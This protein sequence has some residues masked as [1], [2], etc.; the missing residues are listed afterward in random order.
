MG[1]SNVT[2]P[3][4]QRSFSRS[5]IWALLSPCLIWALPSPSQIFTN[6]FWRSTLT[7]QKTLEN[8]E[9]KSDFT[10]CLVLRENGIRAETIHGES[11]RRCW[12]ACSRRRQWGGDHALAARRRRRSGESCSWVSRHALYLYQVLSLSFSLSLEYI[13]MQVYCC[14][15]FESLL[16]LCF[17]AKKRKEEIKVRTSVIL[18]AQ[19]NGYSF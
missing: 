5:S 2:H 18:I 16:S 9:S 4:G 14:S 10:G 13:V 3:K 17:R 19:W 11:W 8:R 15:L 6:L 12:R 7:P 1:F